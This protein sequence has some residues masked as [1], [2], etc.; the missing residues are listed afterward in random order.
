MAVAEKKEDD[1][2]TDMKSETVKPPVKRCSNCFELKP[3]S[4]FY[5][6]LSHFQA[7][8]KQCNNEVCAGYRERVR[9][10]ST[11]KYEMRVL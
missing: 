9:Y 6:K 2:M 7:R 5:R 3:L 4:D 8:C 1:Q 10:K 11:K